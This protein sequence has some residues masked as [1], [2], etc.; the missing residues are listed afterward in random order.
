MLI[1]VF[2]IHWAS[3]SSSYRS[4]CSYMCCLC[5]CIPSENMQYHN[6]LLTYRL[7]K[8]ESDNL[9]MG[10]HIPCRLHQRGILRDNI[11][12][13]NEQSY[14][15][16]SHNFPLHSHDIF[17]SIHTTF[18]YH[19]HIQSK[20]PHLNGMKYNCTPLYHRFNTLGHI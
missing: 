15:H 12:S 9:H 11:L 17:H 5:C 20:V 4:W 18:L 16:R 1:V 3:Y 13:K 8:L 10:I 6:K 14:W 7:H 19:L 2:V